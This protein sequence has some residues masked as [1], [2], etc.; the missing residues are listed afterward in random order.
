MAAHADEST[1]QSMAAEPPSLDIPKANISRF[2][3]KQKRSEAYRKLKAQLKKQKLK[4]KARKKMERKASGSKAPPK[5][6]P[7]TIENMRVYDETMVDPEDEEVAH[8]E[9]HDEMAPYFN[10]QTLPK[11]LITASDIS[12]F[13]CKVLC[14]QLQSCIPNS[15]IYPRRLSALKKVIPQAVER[16]FTDLIVINGNKKLPDAMLVC[17]LPNGPTAHFKLS[18]VKLRKEIKKCG[19]TTDHQPE[20]ILNNFNT[21]L[22]HSVGRLL[23]ALFPHDPD[24]V[25]RRV[26]TFHNQ[27]DFIFFRH[28][29]YIFRNAKKVGLQE[30]GPRF[31]LKLRSLQKGTFDTKFG[32]Y[33]W[34]HKRHEMETSR[35][36]FFL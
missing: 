23:A 9:E 13:K 14:R 5:K 10:R 28:H 19:E 12:R 15:E 18:N 31:T 24:F 34:V 11:V 29:R 26:I 20:L 33:E 27:R 3:N 4:E 6:A 2:K 21:R 1:S 16:G 8:D 35:R 32:E 36:K 25:G 22:G 30:L 7:K 17:H